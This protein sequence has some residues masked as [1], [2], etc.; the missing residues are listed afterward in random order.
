M[1]QENSIHEVSVEGLEV[2][3]RGVTGTVYKY[4][5]D[6]ILKLYDAKVSRQEVEKERQISISAL[7]QGIPTAKAYEMVKSG[8][9]YGVIFEFVKGGTLGKEIGRDQEKRL[10]YASKMGELLKKV[11]QSKPDI[12]LYPKLRSMVEDNVRRCAQFLSQEQQEELLG[13]LSSYPPSKCLLHGDFHENNI[14][15]RD[16]ELV[17]IDLDSMCIGNPLADF[18]Q[19]YC[20]YR[21][22]LPPEVMEELNLTPE[23]QQEFL[24]RFLRAYFPD[25]DEEK[26]K[27]YDELFTEVA[28]YNRFFF[29]LLTAKEGEGEKVSEYVRV[30]YPKIQRLMKELPERFDALPGGSLIDTGI[31][32][33]FYFYSVKEKAT[34]DSATIT[35]NIPI[36]PECLKKAVEKAIKRNYY[37]GL[38]PVLNERGEVFLEENREAVAV[39]PDD[40]SFCDLGTKDSNGYMFKVFYSGNSIRL[41]VFHVLT[42]GRGMDAFMKSVVYYYLTLS[43]HDINSEGMIMTDEMPV[44][45]TETIPLTDTIPRDYDKNKKFHAENVFVIPEDYKYI[46]T[47]YQ[48]IIDISFPAEQFIAV[49]KKYKTTPMPLLGAWMNQV[50][51]SLYNVGGKN[52]VISVPVDMREMN[53]S[54]S[55]GNYCGSI[56]IE[57]SDKRAGDS[58][59]EQIADI[60]DQLK[61]KAVPEILYEKI[62]E[63]KQAEDMIRQ[64]PLD[65]KEDFE[66]LLKRSEE[67]PAR[68][69]Y[70]LTNVGKLRFPKDMEAYIADYDMCGMYS[71]KGIVLGAYTFGDTGHWLISQNFESVSIAKE[72]CE[73]AKE[74]GIDA[75]LTDKGT[76][77]LDS[78]R[79]YRFRRI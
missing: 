42:D 20:S 76:V 78:V 25:A 54:K 53:G 61:A 4:D 62:A 34:V 66:A 40:G 7:E 56:A 27:A 29:P 12:R 72:L 48:K 55:L 59:E 26:I 8:G 22:P 52:I 33:M 65:S 10:S 79:T 41:E 3:A 43:G 30:E 49:T 9:A 69:T 23:I 36:E 44:D 38:T 16:G 47:P 13:F 73:K 19:T 35:L 74:A 17:L 77:R 64:T 18:A 58:T 14:M 6:R 45:P 21:M 57:A 50:L 5:E 24:Y 39:Y 75:G 67:G 28:K 15:V 37:F 60:R 71:G 63:L 32:N 1:Q 2:I 46:K 51:R 11:H 70:T 68:N 31:I